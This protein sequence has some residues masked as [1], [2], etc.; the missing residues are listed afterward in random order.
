MA[1]VLPGGEVVSTLD[2]CLKCKKPLDE[3]LVR[4]FGKLVCSK[5]N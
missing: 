1:N 2:L 5:L 4:G 3:D